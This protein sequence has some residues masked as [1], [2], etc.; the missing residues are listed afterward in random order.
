MFQLG[1]VVLLK[2]VDQE[3]GRKA[4]R[5][6]RGNDCPTRLSTKNTGGYE[7]QQLYLEKNR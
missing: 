6:K 3:E 7:L 4:S 1:S 2:D 5:E